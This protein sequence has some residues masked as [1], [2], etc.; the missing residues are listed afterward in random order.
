MGGN[1]E[2]FQVG[3]RLGE[4]PQPNTDTPALYSW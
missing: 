4:Q 3:K 2:F 1:K